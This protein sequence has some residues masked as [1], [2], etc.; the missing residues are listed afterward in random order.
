MLKIIS[1]NAELDRV[2]EEQEERQQ[3]TVIDSLYKLTGGE[4]DGNE[5]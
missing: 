3:S 2:K 4:G 1:S 5:Q